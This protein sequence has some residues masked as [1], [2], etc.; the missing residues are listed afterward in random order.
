MGELETLVSELFWLLPPNVRFGTN[1]RAPETFNLL[2]YNSFWL[3]L[4]AGFR[5]T[6]IAFP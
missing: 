3:D 6:P 1:G 5:I 4:H 2:C